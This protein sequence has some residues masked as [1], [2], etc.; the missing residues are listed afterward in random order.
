[1][2]LTRSLTWCGVLLAA[3]VALATPASGTPEYAARA[4]RTCDNCHVSPNRWENPALASRKCTLSCQG[5][6]V[7]PAGGG[8]RTVSGRFYGRATL[9]SIATSPRPTADW[10]RNIRGRRDRATSYNDNIPYG[11]STMAD[12]RAY[13]DSI[14]DRWAWGTPPGET[15]YGPFQGRY[16]DLRADPVLRFGGDFRMG[17][18]LSQSALVFP[19]QVDIGTMLHPVHHVTVLANVGARGQS[20]GYS[21]TF[22]DSHTPYFREAFA[23]LHEFPFQAYAK[24]GRFVPS[25]G[26]RLDDHTSR[27]RRE[28]ELDGSLPDARVTGVEVGAA[29]NYPFIQ[30]SYFKLA[31]KYVEPDPWNIFDHDAGWGAA[32][33]AG[34]RELGWSIAGSAMARRRPLDEG[35]DADTYGVYG[36]LNPWFYSRNSPITLQAELDWG[37]Y[38]RRSGREAKHLV[39]Y[40]E[41]DYLLANGVNLLF[42]YDWADPDRDVV[43]DQSGRYQLGMQVTPY[44]G[45]TFDGRLR[46]LQ[47]GTSTGNGVDFF[48]QIHF[49]F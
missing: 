23:L 16:G 26:L 25:Y 44:P 19:M 9:P 15:R 6:H 41:L 20:S 45:V 49:W 4:G 1:M 46:A 13:R 24:A 8:M 42:A 34:I 17:A 28:F 22:D 36:V 48:F 40:G 12:S 47:V 31:S 21:D 7:D 29:P 5:C 32:V 38:Q 37:T 33:N 2:Q 43:D 14:S 11:P 10:D 18:L 30:A 35:G 39:W 3:V 27:I